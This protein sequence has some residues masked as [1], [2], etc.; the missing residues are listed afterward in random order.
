MKVDAV[1]VASSN[2][3]KTIEFYELLGFVFP[4]RK[5]DEQHIEAL[6]PKGGARLMIDSVDLVKTLVGEDPKPSNH[7]SF[8]V[9]CSDP[10]EVDTVVGKVKAAGFTV[11][12]EPW[13][14]FWGQRYAVVS[15][16]D[17]YMVD[18]FANL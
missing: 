2:L 12:K 13:D 5:G 10:E 3:E 14:A 17:G 8:E 18:V 9:I 4:E 1:G 16:P 15:D 11:V 7:S 6:A